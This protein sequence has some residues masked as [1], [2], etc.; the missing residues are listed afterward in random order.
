MKRNTTQ[1][2]T[3]AVTA[4]M[5]A[6]SVLLRSSACSCWRTACA[7]LSDVAPTD[8]LVRSA[9]GPQALR[10]LR[11]AAVSRPEMAARGMP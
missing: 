10:Q 5:A 2:A 3:G 8:R 11:R 4:A 9:G 6:L 1:R 7:S